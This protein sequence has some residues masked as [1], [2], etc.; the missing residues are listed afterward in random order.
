MEMA[1]ISPCFLPPFLPLLSPSL[2]IYLS[3]CFPCSRFVFRVFFIS[4]GAID[5]LI[6]AIAFRSLVLRHDSQEILLCD[7]QRVINN[8]VVIDHARIFV[9]H[10]DQSILNFEFRVIFQC[11]I[12][13]AGLLAPKFLR[14]CIARL[15]IMFLSYASRYF[16]QHDTTP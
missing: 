15:S 13:P 10:S 8:Y 4:A 1:R 5:L 2:S 7:K 6:R 9:S 16:C 12:N 14:V 3:L 11:F